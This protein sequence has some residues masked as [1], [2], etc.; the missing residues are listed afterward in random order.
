MS[1]EQVIDLI[2]R[3]LM[4]ACWVSLPILAVGFV[5]G[6]LISLLQIVTSIQ[7][8]S[9]GSLPRLGAFLIGLVVFLPWMLARA[10]GYAISL[11]GDFSKYAH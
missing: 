9:F 2:R 1:S 8:S 11:L 5:A 10:V 6:A 4:E 7:D 3:A